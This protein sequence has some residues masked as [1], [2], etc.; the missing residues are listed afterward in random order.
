MPRL[1]GRSDLA[2]RVSRNVAAEPTEIERLLLNTKTAVLGAVA[3]LLHARG[4][5]LQAL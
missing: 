5:L 1:D 3:G 2:M 4:A